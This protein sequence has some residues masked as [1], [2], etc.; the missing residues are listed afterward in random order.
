MHVVIIGNGI[1]GITAARYIRKLSDHEITVISAETDHFFSRTALMYVFMGHMRFED[2][3]PYE[4]YFW[5]K[6]RI[7]LLR[8]WVESVDTNVRTVT[9]SANRVIHYDALLLATGSAYNKFGWPG[10]DL[11][12]VQGLYSYQ[13]LELLEQNAARA[14]QAVIVGGGLIGIELG[15][16]LHSRGIK[17]TFLVRESSYWNNVL[18]PEESEMVSRHI[19]EHH[20]DLRLGTELKEIK[21]D[22]SGHVQSVITSR[23]E[24]IPC[25]IVGLTAGVHPNI[26]LAQS[27]GTIECD[28]GILVDEYLCTSA[29]DVYA[30]GDCVQHRNPPPGHKPIE[31]VWYTGKIMGRAAAH[32]ICGTPKKYEPGFWFNSAKFLDIEYQ[33]Y[34]EVPNTPDTGLYSLYWEHP[35]GK[36]SVRIVFDPSDG[37]TVRGFNLMGIRFRHAVCDQWLREKWNIHEVVR[38]LEAANFDPE[39]S[40]R[41]E[42]EIRQLHNQRFPDRAVTGVSK[43]SWKSMVFSYR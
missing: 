43:K 34:G 21:D 38:H 17:V 27:S 42:K 6:N 23:G 22:G 4:D 26:T 28:R 13:D 35:D 15:E 30:A 41:Y 3:K 14:R 24:E 7:N 16:M 31:Q 37:N 40:K 8:A 2:I 36:K 39:F 33:V 29:P 10:Q 12:G 32:T 5:R 19:L 18:P 25:Q 9:T 20:F 11:E 1:A